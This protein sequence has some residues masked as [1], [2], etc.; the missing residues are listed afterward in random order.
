MEERHDASDRERHIEQASDDRDRLILC[1]HR[2]PDN[3]NAQIRRY[4]KK[5]KYK[6]I[7]NGEPDILHF[8]GKRIRDKCKAHML[9]ISESDRHADKYDPGQADKSCLV[10]PCYRRIKYKTAD[11][12]ISDEDRQEN[13]QRNGD[14]RRN[15]IQHHADL[16]KC[17]QCYFSPIF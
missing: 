4:Y 15:L 16:L 14:C 10:L 13:K 3:G 1:G 9:I 7:H 8:L 11:N 5:Y 6:R 12:R 17:F 2:V